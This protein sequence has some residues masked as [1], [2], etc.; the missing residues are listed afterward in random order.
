MDLGIRDARKLEQPEIEG[1]RGVRW[2]A[3]VDVI[4]LARLLRASGQDTLMQS[5]AAVLVVHRTQPGRSPVLIERTGT[6]SMI[7]AL[8]HN[9]VQCDTVAQLDHL[10]GR[11]IDDALH[12]AV[13]GCALPAMWHHLRIEPQLPVSVLRTER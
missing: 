9:V 13:Y 6:E 4:R 2:F 3:G 8:A 10:P 1:F 12:V 7:D 5:A 11:L